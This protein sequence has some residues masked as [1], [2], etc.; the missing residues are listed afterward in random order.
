MPDHL[1]GH[2]IPWR[3]GDKD[4]D[5]G[6]RLEEPEEG[7]IVGHEEARDPDSPI[8]DQNTVTEEEEEEEEEDDVDG[9]DEE[10]EED[11]EDE[12]EDEDVDGDD[13]EEELDAA[14]HHSRDDTIALDPPLVPLKGEKEAIQRPASS[15]IQPTP[16]VHRSFKHGEPSSSQS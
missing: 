7:D 1:I 5:Q 2:S 4:E 6:S 3:H 10:D 14:P 9:D 13:E 8:R 15:S 11:E 12:D 16:T